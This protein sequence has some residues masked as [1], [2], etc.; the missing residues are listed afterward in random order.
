LSACQLPTRPGISLLDAKLQGVGFT[1][2][3]LHGADLFGADLRRAVL[4]KAH[5]SDANLIRADLRH[6]DLSRADLSGADLSDANLKH[7]SFHKADLSDANLSNA[8]MR[9]ANLDEADLS[10]ANLNDTAFLNASLY[11]ANL[12]GASGVTKKQLEHKAFGVE[13]A[14][15][16]DTKVI[17]AQGKFP[18]EEYVSDEFY[19]PLSF[20]VGDGWTV[21]EPET[22]EELFIVT[23]P[24]G[25]QLHFTKPL[26]VYDQSAPGERKLR[27]AP[28][29]TDEWVRWLQRHPNLE[30]SKP[31]PVRMDGETGVQIDVTATSM[32]ANCE[33]D[34]CVPLFPTVGGGEI[35]SGVQDKDRFVIVDVGGKTVV[36][37]AF[38]PADTTEEFLP[39]AEKVLNTVE[40]KGA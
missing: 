27:R 26:R 10:D 36:I 18:A 38:A 31:V 2:A 7:T 33:G 20:K 23:G 39:K 34:P 40:W 3:T 29:N 32:Q 8:N 11:N 37:D 35:V 22:P 6:A 1:N 9:D 25:E 24:E 5:L 16:P 28:E 21:G 17:P 30:S 4:H 13:L 19:P 15:I 14:T 12:S